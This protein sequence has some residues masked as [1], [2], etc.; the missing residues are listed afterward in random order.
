MP[1]FTHADG[2]V[3]VMAASEQAGAQV[4][5]RSIENVEAKLDRALLACEALWTL[6]RD[7]LGLTDDELIHRINELDLS[8]GRLDGKVSRSAVSCPSCGRAIARRFAKCMYCG[9]AIMQDPF[10]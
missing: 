7:R 10:T 8:D 6:F 3:D 5:A 9:Q 4:R 1:V 2:H